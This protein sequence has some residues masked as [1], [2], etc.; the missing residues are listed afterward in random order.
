ME[1]RSRWKITGVMGAVGIIMVLVAARL[2]YLEE[3][4]NFHPITR[5]IA[6]RAAQL[7]RDELEYYC[8]TYGIRSVL[9]LRGRK[10]GE[11]WYQEEVDTCR[12]LGV[13]HYDLG[14]SADKE[15]SPTQV[16]ALIHLFGTAPRPVLVHCQGGADRSGLA[17]ALWRMVV[18]RAPKSDAVKQLSIRYGHVPFGPTQVLDD[19]LERWEPGTDGLGS[20]K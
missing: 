12:K 5:G 19:F 11:K 3:Q 13:S 15:P 1:M 9:N 14:L 10:D 16:A 2:Y 7:D 20:T 6:Y 4:G 18:D 8:N 17:A